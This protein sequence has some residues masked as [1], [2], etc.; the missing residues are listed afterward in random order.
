LQW[1]P[2]RK[3]RALLKK[4]PEARRSLE[5]IQDFEMPGISSNIQISPDGEFIIATGVYKPRVRCYDVKNLSMK[6]ERCFDSEV[7]K[8]LILSE[9]YS[10]VCSI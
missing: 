4:D 2:D 1:L 9:D 5:L 6:F 10:K 8:F 7:V 3:R